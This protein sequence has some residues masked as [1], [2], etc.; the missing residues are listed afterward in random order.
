MYDHLGPFYILFLFHF[1]FCKSFAVLSS[2]INKALLT[3]FTVGMLSKIY[4]INLSLLR[5]ILSVAKGWLSTLNAVQIK[6]NICCEADVH[7]LD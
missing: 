1:I 7:T 5:E 3:Y 2:D 4:I 6:S